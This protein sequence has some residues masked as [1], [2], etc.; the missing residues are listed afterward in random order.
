M[1]SNFTVFIFLNTDQKTHLIK[2]LGSTFACKSVTFTFTEDNGFSHSAYGDPTITIK[3]LRF[4]DAGGVEL[5]ISGA[6]LSS[7]ANNNC[8]EWPPSN[9][10]D[11]DTGTQAM[12]DPK[13]CTSPTIANQPVWLKLDF[14]SAI[15]FSSY[16]IWAGTYQ[17][18]NPK[19]WSVSCEAPD[20]R[21]GSA[22]AA[23]G[24]RALSAADA[25]WKAKVVGEDA[26]MAGASTDGKQSPVMM[27][28][29][30]SPSLRR[31]VRFASSS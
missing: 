24:I 23:A 14:A 22:V 16:D 28:P 26:A 11:G 31:T 4:H 9:A 19:Q 17:N 15:D 30:S 7:N 6:S 2:L 27:S 10:I 20:T 3:E 5:D 8:A 13:F 25:L 29:S 1:F 18:Q 21:F 12:L